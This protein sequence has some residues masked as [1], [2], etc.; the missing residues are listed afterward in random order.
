[1][2]YITS[3]ILVLFLLP[4][5]ANASIITLNFEGAINWVTDNPKL[6]TP[7]GIGDEYSLSIRYDDM[8][9]SNSG[10]TR[11]TPDSAIPQLDFGSPI[12]FFTEYWMKSSNQYY[13]HYLYYDEFASADFLNGEIIRAEGATDGGNLGIGVM[14]GHMILQDFIIGLN[15]F[16]V[17]EEGGWYGGQPLII[18]RGG[19]NQ[20]PESSIT[21]LLGLGLLG[22]AVVSKKKTSRGLIIPKKSFGDL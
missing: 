12:E 9:V 7:I 17:Y 5:V 11:L 20:V 18:A 2:K 6:E 22:L 14:D 21:F 3:F 13:S 10:S 16:Q 8:Y 1:M 15:S 19:L 4:V